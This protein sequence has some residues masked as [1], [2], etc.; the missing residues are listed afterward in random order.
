MCVHIWTHTVLFLAVSPSIICYITVSTRYTALPT[1]LIDK[2][3]IP[4]RELKVFFFSGNLIK[5]KTNTLS[6]AL[7]LSFFLPLAHFV[8][9]CV[10]D[11]F[12]YIYGDLMAF[13]REVRKTLT[14]L[15]KFRLCAFD[16]CIRNI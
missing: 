4:S 10:C 11:F 3:E 9:L 6:F 14:H 13:E 15:K 8:S 2:C 5:R 7:F 16:F 1:A 12:T